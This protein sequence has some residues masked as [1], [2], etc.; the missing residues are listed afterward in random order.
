MA[1]AVEQ[2]IL[3]AELK[4]PHKMTAGLSLAP[5]ARAGAAGAIEVVPL[6][7]TNGAQTSEAVAM[8]P[9]TSRRV[10]KVKIVALARGEVANEKAAVDA[11]ANAEKASDPT[12]NHARAADETAALATTD[13]PLAEMSETVAV[14]EEAVAVKQQQMMDARGR[15]IPRIRANMEM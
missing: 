8:A 13:E 7:G 14:E 2:S 11:I 4:A 1:E 6:I 3:Q 5:I 15:E 9:Q 12:A 10:L